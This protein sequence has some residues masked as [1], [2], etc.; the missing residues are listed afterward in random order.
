MSAIAV[1]IPC[2]NEV[3]TIARVVRDFRRELPTAQIYVFDNNSTDRTIEEAQAAGAIVQHEVRQ[4]KGH[5]LR[6]MF[7]AVEADAYVMV[8]GDGTYPAD[9]VH[10]LLQPVLNGEA[11]M[12]IG[13]RLQSG[14]NSRF[15]FPNLLGNMAFRWLL[16]SF[17]RVH[18]TDLLSGYRAMNRRVV[19]GLPFLSRGFE[20]ETELTVKCLQRGLHIVEVPVTLAPRVEGSYSKIRMVHD[21]ILI[22]NTLFSLARDY[23]PLTAFGVIGLAL[24]GLG[25][26]P[27]TLVIQEYLSTGQVLRMPSAIL[28]AALLLAGLMVCFAGLA[29]H[30]ITRRFQELDAQMQELLILH[31]STHHGP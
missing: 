29:L 1:L 23:K 16:N 13:S 11:D 31:S 17:F 28:A 24:C 7:H 2:Y 18:V 21:G 26:I 14:A 4:G 19:K 9:R 30:T 15:K 22:L 12:V 3:Q 6:A 25:L 5:V 8:D 10:D 20:S 27:G